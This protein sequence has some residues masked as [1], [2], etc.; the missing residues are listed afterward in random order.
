M[1]TAVPEKRK[2]RPEFFV[3]WLLVDGAADGFHVSAS[4]VPII[5]IIVAIG[6]SA[7]MCNSLI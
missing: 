3:W 1:D 2:S 5:R 6:I 4:G 7:R